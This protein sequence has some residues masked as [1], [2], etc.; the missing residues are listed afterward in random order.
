MV[1]YRF[2]EGCHLLTE[3]HTNGNDDS[4]HIR[5]ERLACLMLRS[6]RVYSSSEEG[7]I[8]SG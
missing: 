2:G 7:R 8:V 5:Q 3:H 4:Q 6:S 1:K